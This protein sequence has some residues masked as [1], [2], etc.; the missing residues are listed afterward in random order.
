[1]N[2]NKANGDNKPSEIKPVR[3]YD[4]RQ[5][6]NTAKR[7]AESDSFSR[8]ADR[9]M[10]Y[11][12]WEN[13]IPKFISFKIDERKKNEK[14]GETTN[15]HIGANRKNEDP[16]ANW[17]EEIWIDFVADTGDSGNATYTVA[18]T[19]FEDL[20]K[21]TNHALL[22][23]NNSILKMFPGGLPRADLLVLGGDLVYPVANEKAY[24]ERFIDIFKAA[25][26]ITESD[27]KLMDY[28]SQ[29]SK[30]LSHSVVAF[31]QNHDWYDNLSSFT[32]LFFHKKKETFL[33]MKCPQL[34]SYVAVEL[35]HDWWLFGLDFA[36]TDDIDEF[37][38]E[39]FK[40]IIEKGNLSEKSR[41]II[42]YREP[43]WLTTAQ[44]NF[45]NAAYRY[46]YK[47]LERLIEEKNHRPI[48]VRL[49]G[50]QHHY[51]RYT[52]SSKSESHLI[53]CGC[54]GAFLHPTHG[55]TEFETI[56]AIQKEDNSFRT[57]AFSTKEFSDLKS[58]ETITYQ[59][60]K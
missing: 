52:S 58:S 42:E 54:G 33:D 14:K 8:N 49:S 46:R 29:D 25:L 12:D 59:K 3:W 41:I 11:T 4:F 53:T 23:K 35:P 2:N 34:Q 24:K 20:L 40:K 43:I 50:D 32:L 16:K 19:L 7:V 51:R 60:K 47:E 22:K 31:P 39:Y 27:R 36:L 5:L 48:D 57:Y 18:K 15:F 45:E 56:H 44:G 10:T 6:L 26:P 17:K 21:V 13:D 37:Q 9:R 38:L 30:E 1:M 28:E 55:P